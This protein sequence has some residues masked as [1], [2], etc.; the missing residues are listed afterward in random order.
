MKRLTLDFRSDFRS[1]MF[2]RAT[3]AR[4]QITAATFV[5]LALG[6][7]TSAVWR[8]EEMNAAV[9]AAR[10]AADTAARAASPAVV[11]VE[12]A[13]PPRLAALARSTH[14]LNVPWATI[15]DELEKHAAKDVAVLAIDPDAVK[16]RVRLEFEA[17][18]LQSLVDFAQRLGRSPEFESVALAKHE[19]V[20]RDP[21]K[22]VR[23]SLEAKLARSGEVSIE[24]KP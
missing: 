4:M 16:G 20:D 23:M 15:L 9:L 3:G 11:A 13:S 7:L 19:S 17:R 10:A 8:Y 1:V 14:H 2:G 5:L 24:D 22:P 12:T 21:A 18:Q 6:S